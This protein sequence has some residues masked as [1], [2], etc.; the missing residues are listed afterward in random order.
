MEAR[1]IS[2][3]QKLLMLPKSG[4]Y[5]TLPLLKCLILKMYTS[6]LLESGY[7]VRLPTGL[8]KIAQNCYH[9]IVTKWKF[10]LTA[11]LAL[12]MC[13]NGHWIFYLIK[14][15]NRPDIRSIPIHLAEYTLHVKKRSLFEHQVSFRPPAQYLYFRTKIHIKSVICYP[16]PRTLKR[17]TA[18]M[19]PEAKLPRW[20]RGSPELRGG[21]EVARRTLRVNLKSRCLG[22][23][24]SHGLR[25][26]EANKNLLLWYR[27]RS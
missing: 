27:T 26:R 22:R 2:K 24:M 16:S 13:R 1:V 9:L 21:E 18:T 15:L 25:T 10:G 14:C 4:V 7:D 5:P 6:R 17:P 23:I 8:L 3:L 11:H 19:A 12:L 20:E